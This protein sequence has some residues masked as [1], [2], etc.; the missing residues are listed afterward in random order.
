VIKKDYYRI[1]ELEPRFGILE[2]DLQY[3]LDNEK[4]DFVIPQPLQ[5]YVIG[6]RLKVGGFVGYGTVQYKGLIGIPR[7]RAKLILEKGK[8]SIDGCLLIEQGKIT[9]LDDLYRFSVPIPND[10]VKSWQPKPL[11]EIHWGKV[12]AKRYPSVTKNS[13]Q[14]LKEAFESLVNK[15]NK[16]AVELYKEVNNILSSPYLEIKKEV[17]CVTHTQLVKLS[18]VEDENPIKPISI[19]I[20]RRDNAFRTLVKNLIKLHPTKG[21]TALWDFLK[22]N[23]ESDE[24]LDPESI[25]DEVG[26]DELTWIDARKIERTITK[27]TFRN[28][29][30]D[31]K[32]K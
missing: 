25:L 18:L 32:K 4:I 24:S 26:R 31:E 30:S 16:S 29:V 10:F 12:S 19:E 7:D 2:A 11:S 8:A 27:K 20:A 3:W 1:D 22:E 17:L 13:Q 5:N 21:G 14:F 6:G 28:M 15:D 23:H 9:Y